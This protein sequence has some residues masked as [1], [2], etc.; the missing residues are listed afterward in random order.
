MKTK[1]KTIDQILKYLEGFLPEIQDFV[2]DVIIAV[3]ILVIGRKLIKFISNLLQRSL[4]KA[5]VEAGAK[6]FIDSC[7]KAALYVILIMIIVGRFGVGTSS[8]IAVV[9]SAGLTIG[10]A[11]QG[12]LSNFAGGVVILVMKPYRVG[13]YVIVSNGANEGT[14][15]EIRTFYTSLIAPDGQQIMIPNGNLA[16]N[17]IINTSVYGIRQI[18]I[19]TTISSQDN[20]VRA[21]ELLYDIVKSYDKTKS[22]EPIQ[23]FVDSLEENK[24][25][26]GVRIWV[27]QSD[28]LNSKWELTEKIKISMDENGFGIPNKQL[29]VHISN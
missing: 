14:V 15:K 20:I 29:D 7:V 23:V 4:E 13:D 28:Y 27:D 6:Q 22:E 21:K 24:V 10:L 11:L 18:R 1:Q 2:I 25:T 12:S 16:N 17:A 5:H 26:I 3:L 19:E 8:I 9:G